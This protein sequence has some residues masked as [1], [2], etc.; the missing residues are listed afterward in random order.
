M[1]WSIRLAVVCCV[2]FIAAPGSRADFLVQ[3]RSTRYGTSLHVTQDGFEV[4][5]SGAGSPTLGFYDRPPLT[6]RVTIATFDPPLTFVAGRIT[7]LAG[8]GP[9]EMNLRGHLQA[10]VGWGVDP[11]AFGILSP[12]G[13]IS[14]FFPAT[15]I[16]NLPPLR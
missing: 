4:E 11:L 16:S 1:N 9:I 5:F 2:L 12:D 10:Q 7:F 13:V 8:G 6:I 3:G 14:G 15:D